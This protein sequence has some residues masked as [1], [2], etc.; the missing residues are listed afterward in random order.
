MLSLGM[1]VV[2]YFIT[3][4]YH[5]L[6]IA[7]RFAARPFFCVIG[8]FADTRRSAGTAGLDACFLRFSPVAEA[9]VHS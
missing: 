7:G 9:D 4:K 8:S 1:I 6:L 2:Y 5:L 3:H